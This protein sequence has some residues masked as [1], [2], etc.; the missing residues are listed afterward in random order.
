M[1]TK[2]ENNRLK[3]GLASAAVLCVGTAVT[4]MSAPAQADPSDSAAGQ[5]EKVYVCKYVGKP[6]VD[7]RLQTGQ[8]PIEVSVNAI[9]VYTTGQT[10]SGLIGKEFADAQGR[11]IVIAVSPVRG[12]GQSDEPTI[13]DCPAPVGPP[14]P[15]PADSRSRSPEPRPS[16]TR[17]GRTT[18]SSARLRRT[19]SSRPSTWAP[20]SR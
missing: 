7:E 14:P 18:R 11:S 16:P 6:G 2:Y 3:T 10:A 13:T 12:G 19:S 8:N 15:P 5:P 9:P 17:A 20:P 4:V 1:P